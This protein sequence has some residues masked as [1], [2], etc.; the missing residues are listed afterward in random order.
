MQKLTCEL[1]LWKFA[2]QFPCKT[3]GR[4]YMA[5]LLQCLLYFLDQ[6]S[7]EEHSM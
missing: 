3:D 1:E 6:L 2:L 4:E 5:L 7:Y